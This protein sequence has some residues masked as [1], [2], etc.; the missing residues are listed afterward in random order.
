MLDYN[1]CYHGTS[2]DNYLSIK[3][4]KQFNFKSRKNHWLGQGVYFYVEDKDKAIW[5]VKASRSPY[6]RGKD[7][8]VI[9]AKISIEANDLLNLDTENGRNSLSDF[10]KA[11]RQEGVK[12]TDKF[13]VNAELRCLL[14]DTYNKYN[15][16][17]AVKYTFADDKITY[18]DLNV[19][20]GSY[21]RIR[22]TGIQ[23]NVVNQSI[24]NFDELSV[25]CI[26]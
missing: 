14:I 18:Q 7:K 17:K 21:D 12:V 2:Y 5:F 11:L 6:L 16:I 26:A 22:N 13:K 4:S 1:E 10:A 9:Q 23:I 25:E 15:D 20:V 8:C 24:I 19:N 3:E